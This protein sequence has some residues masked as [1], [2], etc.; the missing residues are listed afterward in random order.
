[1]DSHKMLV[2]IKGKDRTD[3]IADIRQEAACTRVTY[4][5]RSKPYSYHRENVSVYQNP[6]ELLPQDYCVFHHGDLVLHVSR[7]Q[8]FEYYVRLYY[9]SG[10]REVFPLSETALVPSALKKGNTQDRFSY[11]QKLAYMD[12][13]LTPGG[14]PILGK[15]FGRIQSIQKESIASIYLKGNLPEDSEEKKQIVYYPFGFNSSQK[16]A[17]NYALN[18]RIS[19][20][21]GPPGT[22][23][24]Q[25]ILNILAN[26]V[27]QDGTAAVVSSNNS[28]TENVEEKLKKYEVDF[29][30]AFLGSRKNKEGFILQQKE[31]P[32]MEDWKIPDQEKADIK[33]R[34]SRMYR[35]LDKQLKQRERMAQLSAEW[36][37]LKVEQ[38]HFLTYYQ[39]TCR[40]DV[41]F[42]TIGKVKSKALLH[43]MARCEIMKEKRGVVSSWAK[44]YN[45]FAFGIYN[46][47]FYTNPWDRIMAV[48]QKHY[49]EEREKELE[50]EINTLKKALES[51][52]FA[53]QMEEYTALSMK[54]FRHCLFLRYHNRKREQY[55]EA[56]LQCRSKQFIQDYPIILSTAHSL[57]NSLNPEYI[58]DYVIMDEASQINVTTGFLAFSCARRAVVVGDMKQL[59][60]VVDQEMKKRTDAVFQEYHMPEAY[61][62][63]DHSMLRSITELFLEIPI[64]MLR[65]HYR[66][67]PKIIEFCNQ[68]FYDGRLIIMTEE[69]EKDPA[70]LM[71]YKTVPGNHARNHLNQREID[72]ICEEVLPQ[73]SQIP[74]A[75]L[76]IV[77]PYRNQA[78]ALQQKLAGTSI[79][80]DTVDKFQGQERDTIILSTVDNDI[81]DFA[82]DGHRLN[83]AVSRAVHRLIIVTT[84]N[85]PARETGI[86]DL[87]QYVQYNNM[88]VMNS[89]IYSVF[90][91]LY[92][93]Y[94]EIR[95]DLLKKWGRVSEYDSENLMYSIIMDV[96]KEEKYHSY[97]VL[98][99]VPLRMILRDLSRLDTDRESQFVMNAHTHAD[100][101]IYN[102]F[103][104]QPV[105]IIEV[106][107][108]AYHQNNPVQAERD[109]MKD[110]ICTR[111]HIPLRRFATTGH[112][113][114][115]RLEDILADIL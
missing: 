77:T 40:D 112:N 96:L 69:R 72:V 104:R 76:G 4:L 82:D 49:Y 45:F 19:V 41:D 115:Q 14:E 20:I 50:G 57:R 30:S 85:T 106:D 108:A 44:L 58:Y 84:G 39:E 98:L 56:D 68:K 74:R 51:C 88:D 60:H 47:R 65:E 73:Q 100:F 27:M 67:H 63:S 15:A 28:A 103:S 13:L 37:T 21:E 101:L 31:I 111:Y 8:R 89:E 5:N 86:G 9:E 33:Q 3:E 55:S 12:T 66:C 71:I 53:E 59:S 42:R 95:R 107:G 93:Q 54:M 102:R 38:A 52:R 62:Y 110:R 26:I 81:S 114:K 61:R 10:Q 24:T 7:I 18:N 75:S 97:G 17:V 70:P 48:C 83:V 11:F 1:M 34:L 78:D 29:I 113:E 36:N 91:M 105:L 46:L 99:H 22:G 25:T 2:I 23:K 32:A 43:L 6:K 92:R 94:A 90:D 109:E 64:T 35:S 16:K 87:I 80:A 79:K